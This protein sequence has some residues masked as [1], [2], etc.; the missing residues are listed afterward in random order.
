VL[1]LA[2]PFEKEP[3]TNFTC[4]FDVLVQSMSAEHDPV[5]NRFV[6]SPVL[7][8]AT[9]SKLEPPSMLTEILRS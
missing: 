1:P 5:L 7:H 9:K 3:K 6:D 8:P 4:T 2:A